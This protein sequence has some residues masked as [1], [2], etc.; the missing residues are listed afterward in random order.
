MDLSLNGSRLR[1][2]VAAIPSK[3]QAHRL[4]ICAALAA[5]ES[6]VHCPRLNA[7][8]EATVRCLRALGAEIGR[9]GEDFVVR[10]I[11]RGETAPAELDC[12]ESGSTLRFLLPVAAALGREARFTGSGRLPQRP[13]AELCAALRSGGAAVSADALPITVSGRLRA[14]TY[15]LPAKV[16]SQYISGLLFTL[17]LL[18][19]A[20]RV[21]LDGEPES[22]PYINM[23][24]AALARFGVSTEREGNAWR[25]PAGQTYRSP[26]R[27]VVEGD[28]SN[29]AFWLCAGAIGNEPVTVTG[30]DPASPQGDRAVLDLLGRFGAAVTV[31]EDGITVSP[32]PLH[33]TELDA[34]DVPDLIPVLS[35][36]AACAA[37]ETRVVNAGRL[38]LKESD[39]LSSTAALIRALGGAVTELPEGLTLH[40]GGLRGGCVDSFNDHRLAMAAATASAACREDVTVYGAEAVNK[41]YP[42]F[43]EDYRALGGRVKEVGEP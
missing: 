11:P 34:R 14:G 4:L 30:L 42:S 37:G 9:E 13:L 28:W 26:G 7:D 15:R 24:C 17:P 8:I 25:V 39:R 19:G 35:V 27:V 43:F 18:D 36:V 2:T 22:A 23:T 20:S 33:G 5:G 1:G 3:S 38:R 6:R 29:A 32:A 12:G 40:G 21:E 10:P 41:S 31:G 16:S